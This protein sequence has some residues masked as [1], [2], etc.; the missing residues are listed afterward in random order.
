MKR[1]SYPIRQARTHPEDGPLSGKCA[2]RN[3]REISRPMNRAGQ[4]GSHNNAAAFKMGWMDAIACLTRSSIRD[5]YVS[6][7]IRILLSTA[8][9]FGCVNSYALTTCT[10]AMCGGK[11]EAQQEPEM[12]T[13]GTQ[14]R[15]E[16]VAGEEHSFSIKLEA[17]QTLRAAIEAGIDLTVV[18]VKPDGRGDEHVVSGT[19]E[20]G[21]RLTLLLTEPTG[22]YHFKIRSKNPSGAGQYELTI[23]PATAPPVNIKTP[24][25]LRRDEEEQ[26]QRQKTQLMA[27][28]SDIVTKAREDRAKPLSEQIG[29]L[30]DPLTRVIVE[31]F[32]SLREPAEEDAKLYVKL[33]GTHRTILARVQQDL[34]ADTTLLSYFLNAD[35]PVVFAINNRTIIK[36]DVPASYKE[37]S[38]SVDDFLDFASLSEMPSS[39]L[40]QWYSW[41]ISPIEVDLEASN[42][43][44]V[45]DGALQHIP[46]AAILKD[47]KSFLSEKFNFFYLARLEMF[48]IL[49]GDRG[50]DRKRLLVVAPGGVAGLPFLEDSSKEV[51]SIEKLYKIKRL[52]GPD[53]TKINFLTMADR[54][55]IVHVIAHAECNEHA[56][57]LSY[58]V[59]APDAHKA[60][61][62]W[63]DEV[64]KLKLKNVDLVVLSACETKVC[65]EYSADSISTLNDAFVAAGVPTVIASLWRVNDKATSLFMSAFYKHLKRMS[66][67]AALAEA[68]KEIRSQYPHPYYW[69]A[70][71]LTGEPGP[72]ATKGTARR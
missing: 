11:G 71:V 5:A 72:A 56:P 65:G 37:V 44:I 17:G 57:R 61:S 50:K 55:Q 53:A 8:A 52:T 48:S 43:G 62:L 26:A 54:Y 6:L 25:E 29:P 28:Y 23:E 41:L 70:F 34:P 15:R 64:A 18:V 4:S 31:Q 27:R 46:F 12:L 47:R 24:N 1:S 68:Q 20:S 59:M 51:S 13:V 21:G 7:V 36:R 14:V 67:A 60:V 39:T 69:A 63:V 16:I 19:K 33:S 49:G 9:G 38:S 66:K 45:G 32:A 58:M 35:R 10:G 42:L 3:R 22:T 2:E 40:E 30:E